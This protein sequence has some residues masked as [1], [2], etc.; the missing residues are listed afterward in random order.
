MDEF[1]SSHI[2]MYQV[3]SIQ[4]L[5]STMDQLNQGFWLAE[6]Q[7][8]PKKLWETWQKQLFLALFSPFFYRLPHGQ[9]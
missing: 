6:I 2:E 1:L 4:M 7:K 9:V 5:D 3:D 8:L